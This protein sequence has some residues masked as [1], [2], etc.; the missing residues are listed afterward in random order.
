MSVTCRHVRQLHDAYIDRELPAGLTAEVHAHLLQC[1]ACQQ[2]VEMVRACGGVIASDRSEPQL[3]A[4]FTARIAAAVAARTAAMPLKLLGKPVETRRERRLRL[5]R[6]F[7]KTS[8]PAIAA[9]MFFAIL[10]KPSAEVVVPATAVKGVTVEQAGVKGVVAPTL[11]ALN[12]TRQAVADFNQF[13][14]FAA[15]DAANG[16]S[17]AMGRSAD[18]GEQP[19][20]TT[21]PSLLDFLLPTFDEMLRP[22]N[23]A[24]TPVE[25][26]A[27]LIRL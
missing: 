12:E 18:A 10:I 4:G 14:E 9:M 20:T 6:S 24:A 26:D 7:A 2:Q 15:S 1:P 17:R 22:S 19:P 27:D 5:M 3:D 25:E 23:G 8:I 11:S 21:G 13:V 16:A